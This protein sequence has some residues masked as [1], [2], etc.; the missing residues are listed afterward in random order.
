MCWGGP[1]PVLKITPVPGFEVC[2]GIFPLRTAQ[3]AKLNEVMEEVDAKEEQI[4]LALDCVRNQVRS[5]KNQAQVIGDELEAQNAALAATD[6]KVTTLNSQVCCAQ[7][8]FSVLLFPTFE[9]CFNT[10]STIGFKGTENS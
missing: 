10:C 8:Q 7:L 2:C 9:P 6:N 3:D 5:L 1:P 4:A